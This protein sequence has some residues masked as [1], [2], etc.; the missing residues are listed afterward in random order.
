MKLVI[1]E[2]PTKCNT[3]KKYLGNDYQVMASCGHIRDLSTRGKGGL[4]VDIEHDFKPDYE[5]SKDKY[6]I[7]SELKSA[8]KKASEVYLATD[9]DREGEA[10][11][12]HLCEVLGLDP[13]TTKRLL[14]L[15][16]VGLENISSELLINLSNVSAKSLARDSGCW[17]RAS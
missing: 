9:P 17:H 13:N 10:I 16:L 4:G 6:K 3:I 8:K 2:S 11:S 15:T 14:I 5:N 12:W 1:V 7:I